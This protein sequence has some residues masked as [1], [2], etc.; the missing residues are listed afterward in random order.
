MVMAAP[1]SIIIDPLVAVSFGPF[2]PSSTK[3]NVAI[4]TEIAATMGLMAYCQV[5]LRLRQ[6]FLK[7]SYLLK[8]SI[9]GDMRSSIAS[10]RTSIIYTFCI[11][12]LTFHITPTTPIITHKLEFPF[13]ELLMHMLI[14]LLSSLDS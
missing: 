14:L 1:V 2:A 13:K 6:A 5:A 10:S 8:V 12:F 9:P 7:I 3:M 4:S 11:F